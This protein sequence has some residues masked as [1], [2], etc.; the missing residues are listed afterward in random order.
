[1]LHDLRPYAVTCEQTIIGVMCE[2]P[3][4]TSRIE[5]GFTSALKIC[6][7]H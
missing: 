2:H 1:V 6:M 4:R 7:P 3:T 5:N